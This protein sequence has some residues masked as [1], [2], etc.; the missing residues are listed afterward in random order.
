MK[1]RS[2]K[3]SF[4]KAVMLNSFQHLHLRRGFTLIE[5]LVV[6]LIIGILA[7]VALPQYQ[8]AVDKSRVATMLHL[9]DAVVKAQEVYYL[10]N[11]KMAD[12]FEQL[13]IS[14]PENAKITNANDVKQKAKMGK[15]TIGLA[16]SVTGRPR[17]ILE[18][19][20][21]STVDLYRGVSFG[22]N[23]S[24]CESTPNTQADQ[25]CKN[26]LGAKQGTDTHGKHQYYIN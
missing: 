13:D 10:T 19:S 25:I 15:I 7:A 8:K 21:G 5:L 20:D 23:V 16:S 1:K 17:G 14:L 26:L 2:C 11:G 18:L 4:T 9:L 3:C 24:S 12:K 22:F 6:V